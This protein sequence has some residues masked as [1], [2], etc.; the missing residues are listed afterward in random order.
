MQAGETAAALLERA[1]A[2]DLAL[3]G[4]AP[5]SLSDTNG[6]IMA[7]NEDGIKER[8]LSLERV[9]DITSYSV[10]YVR[11]AVRTGELPAERWGRAYRVRETDLPAWLETRRAAPVPDRQTPGVEPVEASRARRKKGGDP[12]A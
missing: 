7:E 2:V 12:D 8:W 3:G 5:F 1:Q 10:R 11:E 4:P 6:D 9:A